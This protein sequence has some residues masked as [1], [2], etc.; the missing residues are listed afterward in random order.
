MP[1]APFF[2][3][4]TTALAQNPAAQKLENLKKSPFNTDE[5]LN[6]Y[7]DV[8]TYNNFYEFGLDKG[9]PARYAGTLKPRPWTVRGRRAVRQAAAP[10]TSKTS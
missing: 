6:S 8:T 3:G 1:L 9:D 2:E 4:T 5:K 7:R 10:T